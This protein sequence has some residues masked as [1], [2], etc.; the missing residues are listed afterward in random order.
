MSKMTEF[1]KAFG[2]KPTPTENELKAASL[3]KEACRLLGKNNE[4]DV[5]TRDD[6]KPGI[7]IYR[8]VGNTGWPMAHIRTKK[9]PEW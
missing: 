8:V 3:I 5:I 2:K 6:E 1:E 9:V 4:V 7:I